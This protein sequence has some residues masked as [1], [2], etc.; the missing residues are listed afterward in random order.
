MKNFD[1]FIR[2]S[3]KTIK[4]LLEINK[5]WSKNTKKWQF[6]IKKLNRDSC[7]YKSRFFDCITCSIFTPFLGFKGGP[8]YTFFEKKSSRLYSKNFSKNAKKWH[9][10]TLFFRKWKKMVKK[11][12][13]LGDFWLFFAF[14]CK[15]DKKK[16]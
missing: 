3:T 9:F 16:G 14:F 12:R 8:L 6:L 1:S 11:W 4:F 15:N 5:I 7:F 10:L 2:I 13:F